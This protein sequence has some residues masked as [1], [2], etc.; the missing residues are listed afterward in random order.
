[1]LGPVLDAGTQHGTQKPG[2]SVQGL[3]IPWEAALNCKHGD[4]VE[5]SC[6][7]HGII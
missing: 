2:P 4:V 5:E 6:V 7:H 1:M 3:L